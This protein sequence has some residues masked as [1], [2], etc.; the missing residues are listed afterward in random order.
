MR[1]LIFLLTLVATLMCWPALCQQELTDAQKKDILRNQDL[2]LSYNILLSD[3]AFDNPE[4]NY[5]LYQATKH[6]EASNTLW[7]VGG[8]VVVVGVGLVASSFFLLGGLGITPSSPLGFV[9]V[10]SAPIT[11]IS[12]PLFVASHSQKIKMEQSLIRAQQ[13]RP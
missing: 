3:Y 7:T 2:F 11:L 4:F 10:F 12:L 1:Q 5:A 8:A 13:L 6:R 9:A